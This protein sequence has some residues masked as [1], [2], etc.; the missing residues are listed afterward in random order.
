MCYRQ[1]DI[2]SAHQSLTTMFTFPPENKHGISMEHYRRVPRGDQTTPPPLEEKQIH[3]PT[4]RFQEGDATDGTSCVPSGPCRSARQFLSSEKQRGT[5][6][7]GTEQRRCDQTRERPYHKTIP[8]VF[9]S[10]RLQIGDNQGP[11]AYDVG[12]DVDQMGHTQIVGENR[13]FQCWA[14][15]HPIPRL[16]ALQSVDDE[17][18]HSQPVQ[19]PEDTGGRPLQAT[20]KEPKIKDWVVNEFLAIPTAQVFA[21]GFN[22]HSRATDDRSY[23]HVRPKCINHP[24][25]CSDFLMRIAAVAIQKGHTHSP[26]GV[27]IPSAQKHPHLVT[28]LLE[29][30]TAAP[31]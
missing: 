26:E 5:I 12:N 6:K 15:R 31:V 22:K 21:K 23:R 28:F 8:I 1:G 3:G 27:H 20:S 17:F 4:H 14:G 19:T 7:S 30:H 9:A 16:S 25:E 18:R 10:R 24:T 2:D 29:L 11:D 13:L